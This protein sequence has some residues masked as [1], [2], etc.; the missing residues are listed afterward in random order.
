MELGSAT[1]VETGGWLS[2]YE[3]GRPRSALQ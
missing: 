2:I 3:R 1:L